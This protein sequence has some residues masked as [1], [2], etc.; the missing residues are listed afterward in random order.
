MRGTFAVALGCMLMTGGTAVIAQQSEPI[1]QRQ[2]LMKNNQEQLRTLTPIAR[3]QAS[4]DAA[5]VQAALQRIAQNAQQI[6]PVFPAGSQVGETSALPAIW[7]RKADFDAR[8]MKLAQDATAAMATAKDAATLQ[9][10]LQTIGRN[11]VGCHE[12]YRKRP[13]Q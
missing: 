12:P 9:A 6:P 2:A 10:A 11:C 4:F 5:A 13:S 3:G 8:A 7:E 1:R